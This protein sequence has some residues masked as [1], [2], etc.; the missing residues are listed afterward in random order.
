MNKAFDQANMLVLSK[1]APRGKFSLR[2]ALL[3]GCYLALLKPNLALSATF[4]V[5]NTGDS[6]AG[7]LRQAILDANANGGLDAIAFQIPGAGVHTIAPLSTLPPLTDPAIIDGTTQTGFISSPLIEL[8]GTSAGG[9]AGLRLLA[10]GCTVRGLVI[11]R[12]Q[13]DGIDISG[14]G[15]NLVAGNYLGTDP[16][17]LL[18]RGNAFEGI[19]ISGS[20]G[21]LIGGANA[22]DRNLIS[23]NADAGVYIL[24]AGGNQVVGNYIGTTVTGIARLGNTNNGVAINNSAGTTVG[25][26][27]AAFRNLISGNHASGVYLLGAGTSGNLVSGN[28]IGTDPTGTLSLS[29][30]GDGITLSAALNN[31]IGGTGA[32]AGNLIS[33]N[34][35]AGLSLGGGASGNLVQGNFIGTDATGKFALGNSLAGVTIFGAGGN[36]IGGAAA[37]G[38][39]VISGNRQDGIFITTNSTGNTVAGNF[40]GVT[41]AGTNSL[42]NLFNG[43]TISSAS[44]NTV[45]G[46]AAG[47]GNVISGNASYGVHLLNGA[48]ANLL[49]RNFIGTDPTG[50]LPV[51]N[52]LSGVR[53]ESAANTIGTPGAGNVLSGN[54]QDGVFIVGVTAVSN[55]LQGNFIGTT[56]GGSGGLGNGRAGVGLSSAV[57]NFIGAPGAGNVIS[58]NK[59]DAGIYLVGT[60][61]ARNQIQGNIIGADITGTQ[62]LGNFYEGIYLERALT[63]TIG[64]TTP[65]AGNLISAN[66]TRGIWLTNASGNLIQGNFIGTTA[67]GLSAL[68]NTY[69][70]VECEVGAGNN[71]IGGPGGA[72]NKIAFAQ[73]IYA[74]VRIRDGATND[75]ILGNSI[76]SNGAQ[77]ID[78]GAFGVAANDLNDPDGGANFLQNYP[79][80]TQAVAGGGVGVRGTLNSRPSKTFLLQF[81]ASS[82]CDSSGNGEGQIYLGDYTVATAS[83]GNASFVTTFDSA[84]PAGYVI[85]A[86][87]TDGANNTS[88]FSACLTAG[89]APVL[90]VT[91]ASN[92]QM[93][94]SW[95]NST[96]GFVLLQTGSLLPPVQWTTVTNVPVNTGGQFVVTLYTTATNR[97]F[98]LN[99]Q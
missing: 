46:A 75:A 32:G 13:T 26:S 84:V 39:N 71:T 49:Q 63:N 43:V 19:L 21:N 92:Q 74:G 73:T 83:N 55:V 31:V 88:E 95:P 9:N 56:A 81:F 18:A 70:G 44:S 53:I 77:P 2:A 61:T 87:A 6:G 45:G 78:L 14:P 68:G 10:G 12:F 33:G 51:P 42:V 76:F 3:L 91:P 48:T 8:N 34:A 62:A 60:G 59:T 85:T 36:Q 25:G 41:V 80:L 79:V 23:G 40:I 24:N 38:R 52:L 29:N 47:A 50:S 82:S 11:N 98:A 94:V 54:T 96:T 35:K 22:A 1:V 97:F 90:S 99:F 27:T 7:S 93:T 5:I 15:T 86:T 67:D 37:G 69:H 28:Y 65:G 30:L 20:S 4:T 66:H 57:A 17:G 16:T 89:A 64:G 72:G 58:A